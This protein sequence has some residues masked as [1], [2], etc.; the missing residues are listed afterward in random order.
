[1]ASSSSFD[2]TTGVDYMEVHNAVTQA[3]KE[4]TQRFD[5][6]G[7]KVSLELDQKANTI[8]LAAPDEFKL[9]AMWDVLQT[10]LVRRQVP[11]KNLKPGEVAPAAGA[12]VRQVIEIQTGLTADLAREVAKAIKD[13]KMKKVQAAI[14]GDT[15][16]DDP[17]AAQHPRTGR[18]QPGFASLRRARTSCRPR[19]RC[20]SSRIWAWSS[21]SG[22][23]APTDRPEKEPQPCQ[24]S[25]SFIRRSCT[26]S[27][28]SC[29]WAWSPEC[30]RSC[31]GNERASSDR[32]RR[33]C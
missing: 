12:S 11:L 32:W 21:S 4:I 14:Q 31:L 16:G 3:T 17:N 5:F 27:S 13:A 6:K 23:S 1:V 33:R 26:S 18:R 10:K 20:S 25:A 30:S 24:I 2:V 22:T 19:S 28:L 8:T 7:L 29:V 15:G 9:K